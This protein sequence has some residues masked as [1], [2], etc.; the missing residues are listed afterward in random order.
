VLAF[1]LFGLASWQTANTDLQALRARWRA[2]PLVG[3]RP[4]AACASEAM[5]SYRTTNRQTLL[6]AIPP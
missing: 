4:A 1:A 2:L 6:R 3:F 5:N